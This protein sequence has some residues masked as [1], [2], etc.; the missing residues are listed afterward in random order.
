M[1]I[2]GSEVAMEWFALPLRLHDVF[3]GEAMDGD[4]FYYN[5]SM[6]FQCYERQVF[7]VDPAMRNA[8]DDTLDNIQT[9]PVWYCLTCKTRRPIIYSA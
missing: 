9:A 3:S 6:F 1:I 8:H 7:W 2:H 4:V 5:P